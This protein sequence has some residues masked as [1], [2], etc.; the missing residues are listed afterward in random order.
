ME[1]QEGNAEDSSK[2]ATRMLAACERQRV[3]ERHAACLALS[4]CVLHF[5][6]GVSND[7]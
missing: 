6:V 4:C 1:W 7:L 2:D 3:G 5:T